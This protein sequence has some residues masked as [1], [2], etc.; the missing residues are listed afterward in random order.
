[1]VH[2]ICARALA[3]ARACACI[4]A[5]SQWNTTNS[6]SLPMWGNTLGQLS[7]QDVPLETAR[8]DEMLTP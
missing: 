4:R 2:D 6:G 5:P 8:M 1:M 7:K 3:S